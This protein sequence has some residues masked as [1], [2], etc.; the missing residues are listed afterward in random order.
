MKLSSLWHSAFDGRSQDYRPPYARSS[1]I[2]NLWDMASRAAEY[3]DV[4]AV[5]NRH[6]FSRRQSDSN[7]DCKIRPTIS[8]VNCL[9]VDVDRIGYASRLTLTTFLWF[10]SLHHCLWSHNICRIWCHV[11]TL[12]GTPKFSDTFIM[13]TLAIIALVEQAAQLQFGLTT[14][15]VPLP[16]QVRLY[17]IFKRN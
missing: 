15:L 5:S 11:N 3:P 9:P 2:Q 7:S 14:S 12:L 8:Y 10:L 1:S 17:L 13:I 4:L 16:S 6:Y